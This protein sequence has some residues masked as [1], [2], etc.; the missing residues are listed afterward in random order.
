MSP[1]LAQSRHWV[2]HCTCLLSGVKRTCRFSTHMSAFD[3]KR[4][5]NSHWLCFGVRPRR[6][7]CTIVGPAQMKWCCSRVGV[8]RFRHHLA[9]VSTQP[10]ERKNSYNDDNQSNQINN[11]VHTSLPKLLVQTDHRV[12][13]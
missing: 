8:V 10:E 13:F 1:L 4:T 7:R 9:R 2:V 12:E 11:I 5:F 6:L 3:P